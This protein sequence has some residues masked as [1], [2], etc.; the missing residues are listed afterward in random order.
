MS[1]GFVDPYGG[2]GGLRALE[3]SLAQA[4]SRSLTHVVIDLFNYANSALGFSA[5]RLAARV[6]Q[7]SQRHLSHSHSAPCQPSTWQVRVYGYNVASGTADTFVSGELYLYKGRG[8]LGRAKMLERWPVAPR[9][10]TLIGGAAGTLPTGW[11]LGTVAGGLTT[12]I[13]RVGEDQYA[14]LRKSPSQAPRPTATA[15]RSTLKPRGRWVLWPARNGFI[16]SV[17]G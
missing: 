15:G 5:A 13:N 16:K 1:A 6:G 4:A 17:C 14:P 10:R 7:H 3:I 12:T 8:K 11:S 2:A 9:N